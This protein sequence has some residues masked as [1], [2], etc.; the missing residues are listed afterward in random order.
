VLHRNWN[1]DN[2]EQAT[3]CSTSGCRDRHFR[4]GRRHADGTGV[5]TTDTGTRVP[6]STIRTDDACTP[7][8]TLNRLAAGKAVTGAPG[9]WPSRRVSGDE[10]Q[11]DRLAGARVSHP[12]IEAGMSRTGGNPGVV[13][14]GSA[15]VDSPVFGVGVGWKA[16]AETA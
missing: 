5:F 2:R 11:H 6:G 4:A 3:G 16:G 9:A 10:L 8:I 15:A 7:A 14:N 1:R 12:D 13:G